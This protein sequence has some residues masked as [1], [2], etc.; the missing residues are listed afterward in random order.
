ML[1]EAGIEHLNT[2]KSAFM[3]PVYKGV[4]HIEMQVSL[5][6]LHIEFYEIH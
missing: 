3:L 6:I 5:T 2:M 1:F 4:V